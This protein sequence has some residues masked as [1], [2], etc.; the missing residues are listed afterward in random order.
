MVGPN[1]VFCRYVGDVL[2]GLGETGVRLSTPAELV[3]APA[4][5]EMVA[6]PAE[7]AAAKAE[8][9]MAER[10]SEVVLS[11]RR[12]LDKVARVGYPIHRLAVTPG[13]SARMVAS[14]APNRHT[15]PVGPSSKAFA[16]LPVAPVRAAQGRDPG[17]TGSPAP[18]RPG[19]GD[20]PAAAPA[21]RSSPGGPDVARPTPE[22]VVHEA[23]G[24][25]V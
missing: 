8:L 2:P 25:P 17:G 20:R 21:R 12:P 9:A 16:P 15:G 7:V 10:L 18:A 13:D 19:S 5:A 6:D 23:C 24:P 11:H 14:A 4:G 1:T 22:A 3:A